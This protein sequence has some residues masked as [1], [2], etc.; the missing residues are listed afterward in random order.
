MD[1]LNTSLAA[2]LHPNESERLQALRSYGILDTP[3]EPAFD[4]ITRL[5]SY[6]CQTPISVINL[7]DDGRQWFKSEI[8]LGVRETPID[9]SLCA[10]AILEQSFMEIPDT[11][12]DRRFANNPLVL[13][14]PHLRFYAGALLRTPD[15]LPL[16]TVCVLDHQP[17]LLT[18]DQRD[19]LAA[20]ARQVMSQIELRRSLVISDRLQ[21][22]VSRLMAVAG[23]DL[24]QPLQ[25]M[26][27]AIDRVRGKLPEAKDRER[28]GHAVDAGM[29]IA[30]DLD[31]LA[32]MSALQNNDGTPQP[33]T[34]PIADVFREALRRYSEEAGFKQPPLR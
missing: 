22:N 28:L 26:V 3:I 32:E 21:R 19:M 15:G 20:L 1:A 4:D 23:H 33:V 29:R 10:H 13:G 34:F 24:K 5:A 31:R 7:I 9:S 6:I 18:Q 14:I 17:R 2:P 30:E 8:G 12:L 16:G 11:T 27:M 25:V